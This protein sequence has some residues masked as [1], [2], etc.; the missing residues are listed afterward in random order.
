MRV[1]EEYRAKD[2]DC[3]VKIKYSEAEDDND[4]IG[5][6]RSIFVNTFTCV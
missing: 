2:P 3:Y 4:K 6:V 5:T 1:L